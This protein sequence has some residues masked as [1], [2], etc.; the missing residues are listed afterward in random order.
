M[1]KIN[2]ELTMSELGN[3]SGYIE[4]NKEFNKTKK[5]KKKKLTL[6]N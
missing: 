5:K 2:K 3:I 1:D 4:Q 6:N